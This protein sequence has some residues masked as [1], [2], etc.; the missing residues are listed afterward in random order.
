M[1][2]V[3]GN[4]KGNARLQSLLYAYKK[5]LQRQVEEQKENFVW[6]VP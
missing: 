1:M 3:L 5:Q 2:F 4:K 6:I